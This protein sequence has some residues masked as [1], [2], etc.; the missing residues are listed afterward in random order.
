MLGGGKV[1]NY[2]Y[3]KREG[4]TEELIDRIF[5]Q[6]I[7]ALFIH[8][9]EPYVT[10]TMYSNSP[11]WGYYPHLMNTPLSLFYCGHT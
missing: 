8:E 6:E 7:T 5:S 3:R 4:G 11:T 1:G 9:N 2:M 10:P